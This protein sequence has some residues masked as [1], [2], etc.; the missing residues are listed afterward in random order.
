MLGKRKDREGQRK[1]TDFFI[2]ASDRGGQDGAGQ[3]DAEQV[4]AAAAQR[5]G[6]RDS[7][8]TTA[9]EAGMDGI[10]TPI[11]SP[12]KQKR[13]L[14][15]AGEHR[16]VSVHE[17][18]KMGQSAA[19]EAHLTAFPITEQPVIDRGALQHDMASFMHS[20]RK[21]LEAIGDRMDYIENKMGDFT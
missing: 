16:E 15:V 11:S 18:E 9:L 17:G 5:R 13:H 6:E 3:A 7:S 1:L 10:T 21:E 20:T 4:E 12:L 8:H 19:H 14:Q 2:L